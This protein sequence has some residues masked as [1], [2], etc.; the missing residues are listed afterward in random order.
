MKIQVYPKRFSF[1]RTA[2]WVLWSGLALWSVQGYG[3]PAD[4]VQRL[5]NGKGF[6]VD[7]GWPERPDAM[8]WGEMPGVAIDG[9]ERIWLFTREEPA[10]QIYDRNGRFIRSWGK[11]QFKKPHFLRIDS[12]GNVW[13]AD[14]GSHVVQKFSP[15][16]KLLLTL[17]TPG[18]AGRD[19]SHFARPAD[20]AVTEA[21]DIFVGDGY[22][23]HRV[24]HYDK[25]GKYVKE[26]GKLG[27]RRGEFNLVHSI[28]LDSTG[29]LYVA[30]RDNGRIQVFDQ[31][32]T[33]LDEWRDLIMPW[34]IYITRDDAIWVC[35]SS[36]MRWTEGNTSITVPPKDQIIMQ[37]DRTGKVQRLWTVP[38][39][40]EGQAK[41]GEC[42]WVHGIAVDQ[43]G[44]LYLTDIKGKRAQKF[45]PQG[46]GE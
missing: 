24:V 39:G 42:V 1:R 30:D 40:V 9:Q 27:T 46:Q 19:R 33:F 10:I 38:L 43:Q 5:H 16:G 11:G 45:V 21:G 26:W 41:P 2:M 37:F 23:N 15:Q 20:M 12:A 17:G 32:G 34:G 13:T 4:P 8:A 28:A 35:G 14:V 25:N 36:P 6:E 44:A 7:A 22:A 3:Q 18:V 31:N 29:R